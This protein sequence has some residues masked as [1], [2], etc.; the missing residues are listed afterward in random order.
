[1]DRAPIEALPGLVVVNIEAGL[2]RGFDDLIIIGMLQI[3]VLV[4]SA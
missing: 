4:V 1:M 2:I 3:T